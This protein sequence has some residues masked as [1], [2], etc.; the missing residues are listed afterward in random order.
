MKKK[1]VS[2]LSA[3]AF[4]LMVAVP[5]VFTAVSAFANDAWDVAVERA[6][7]LCEQMTIEEKAGEL[8]VYDYIAL[9]ADGW[10]AYTN[11]VNKGQIGAM[12]RVMR[13]AL[14][15][16]MQEYKMA[17][18]RLK[19]PLIIHEDV[20]YGFGTRLPLSFGMGCS[21][22]DD[23]VERAE[24]V[25]AKEAASCGINLTYSPQADVGGDPRWGR[26]AGTPSEDPYL[27]ARITAARVRGYQ[28]RTLEDL[29]DG[30][31]IVSCV[32]HFV[33]Y[34][35]LQAGKDYRH[36]D[37]SRRELLETHL[38]PFKAAIDAGA[39]GMMNAYTAFE[40]V[41]VNFSRYLM[42]DLLRGELGFRGQ[43]VTDWTTFQFS[44]DEGA[45]ED[46]AD[47]AER[48]IKAGVDMDMISGAYLKLPQ[49]VRD[50]KISE[51]VVDIAVVRSLA[52]KYLM[53]LFDDPY[54]FCDEAK[55]RRTIGSV[56]N[57]R[58]VQELAE[59]S[60]VLLKNDNAILPLRSGEE[61]VLTGTWAMNSDT[62]GRI[63]AMD[64]FNDDLARGMKEA[65]SVG[66]VPS[67]AEALT[68]R[69][70]VRVTYAQLD[71]LQLARDFERFPTAGT[72]ILTLGD[73]PG[74]C[75]ERRGRAKFQLAESELERLRMLK[76]EG[77]RIITIVFAGRPLILNEVVWLSDAVIFAGFPGVTGAEALAR[78]LTG[79]VNP[80]GKLSHYFPF[81]AAQVPISYREK[82]TFIK[83]SYSDMTDK[84]LFPFGFGLGYSRFEYSRP[85]AEKTE[86]AVGEP[87]RVSV[88]VRNAGSRAG[89][90]VVQLY[91]R[92][93]KA[94]VLPRERELKEYASV[95]LEA[96]EEKTVSFVLTDDAFALYDKDLK[97]VVEPGAFTVFVGPD[98][99]TANAVSVFLR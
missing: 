26:V 92:D 33:G 97:R 17:H 7:K 13:P 22:D 12:M 14:T 76:R 37:F 25:A 94:S 80:S 74:S 69:S 34:S 67:L 18:S 4:A 91:V 66:H 88:R 96:G 82:R 81:D 73:P 41:P 9:G 57:R 83:C 36:L 89:R 56:E 24:A 38:L 51:E 23:A 93:E 45:A 60:I 52:L 39:L 86:F 71:P 48:G 59:K 99:T 87:V 42:T 50:G 53:G 70:D 30:N 95:W 65:M 90:E 79:E 55:A 21:W 75:G 98:S 5:L 77:K 11:L 49:L 64:L 85:M 63:G 10:G 40:G 62:F 78:I 44:I 68:N 72:V 58:I 20:C 6:K 3:D 15:R 31:H 29:K 47:A 19:I 27:A 8:L 32:K 1:M 46:L 84:P 35:S 28:G 2:L 61:Y 54:R 43:L 16:R